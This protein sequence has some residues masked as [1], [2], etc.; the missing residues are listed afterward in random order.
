MTKSKWSKLFP[1][2]KR[3]KADILIDGDAYFLSVTEAIETAREKNDYIYIL[4]WMLD[5]D[6]ELVAGSRDKTL[7]ELLR[8]AAKKGVEIRILIWDNLIP[9]YSEFSND[10][11]PRLNSLPNTK[12]F[13]DSHTFFPKRS[14]EILSGKVMQLLISAIQKYGTYMIKQSI[15][16]QKEYGV[17][18]LLILSKLFSFISNKTIGS[19][20]EKVVIVK[21]KSGLVAFCGGIDFNKNRIVSTINKKEHRFPYLHDT[22]CRLEGLAAYEILQRFKRR[23]RNH[24]LAKIETIIGES[25]Q[26]PKEKSLPYPYV[27]VVGTYNSIDGQE[28]DRSLSEA[29]LAIINN[30]EKYIYIE[31][32]YLVN[33][34]VARALNKK[35]KDLNF[36]QLTF[37]I[38]DS[39][40]T[41]DIFIPNRKRSEFYN[42]VLNDLTKD[43]KEKVLLSVIDRTYWNRAYYHPAMHAK[44][45][46]VDDEITIIGSANVN[47]RS[48]TCDSETSIVIFDDAKKTDNNFARKFRIMTWKDYEKEPKSPAYQLFC[49]SYLSLPLLIKMTKTNKTILIKYTRDNKEDLDEKIKD[50]I[51]KGGV[52]IAIETLKIFQDLISNENPKNTSDLTYTSIVLSPQGIEQIFNILWEHVVDPKA[53]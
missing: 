1:E 22:A 5:I 37:V 11:I 40:E 18:T 24:P 4:G 20:H 38:Q 53:D 16:I 8:K 29:Y 21:G 45:L 9:D 27:K 12:A 28:K 48:F 50:M 30:A 31:D 44:T 13:I 47:Q 10:F 42:I 23:W 39:I 3:S 34:D 35:A 46:I 17:S 32:Q 36:K 52:L 15:E 49:E 7:F 6:I 41:S 19:H 33:T 2:A 26:K 43:Q 25:E 51:K 14:K